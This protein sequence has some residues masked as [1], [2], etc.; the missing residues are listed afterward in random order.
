MNTRTAP[1]P[2]PFVIFF[3]LFFFFFILLLRAEIPFDRM[4]IQSTTVYFINSMNHGQAAFTSN[5]CSKA[6][7]DGSVFLLTITPI[8]DI[9]F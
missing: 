9:L 8:I 7:L 3:F 6:R 5:F 4:Q 1:F 2:N